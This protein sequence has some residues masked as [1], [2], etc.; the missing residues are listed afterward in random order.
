MQTKILSFAL[1]FAL[2]LGA[3]GAGFEQSVPAALA[4]TQYATHV[5]GFTQV[6]NQGLNEPFDDVNS[7][8]GAPDGGSVDAD[9]I[10]SQ[11][12]YITVGFAPDLRIVNGN[13]HDFIVHVEDFS[14]TSEQGGPENES[15]TVFASADGVNFVNF[16]SVSPAG[17]AVKVRQAFGFDLD[18]KLS[19]V[20]FVRIQNN[21]VVFDSPFEG[22]EVDAVEA[23]N[24]VFGTP[25]PTPTAPQCSDAKDNDGDGKIDYP[26]DLGCESPADNDEND[27]PECS[28]GRDNDGDGKI[29][30]K[31]PGCH[32]DGNPNNDKSFDSEDNDERDEKKV[33]KVKAAT[34]VVKPQA[35]AITAK[36]G[37]PSIGLITTLTGLTGLALT[38]RRWIK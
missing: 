11:A 5:V 1:V 26:A 34:V 38:V 13:G 27:K 19:E 29:D 7:V 16:G 28:D 17:P 10:G 24:F 20:R 33:V 31:D 9:N 22:P 37:A 25:T 14:T 4:A 18:G 30:D 8:I 36:T 32:T 12:G 23:V 6:H 15:F 2:A 3:V 21:S 35:V